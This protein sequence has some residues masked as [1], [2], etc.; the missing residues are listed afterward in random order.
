[1]DTPRICA[2]TLSFGIGSGCVNELASEDALSELLYADYLVLIS[3]TIDGLR[4]MFR[5]WK[6]AFV[7]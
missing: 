5:K 6:E 2:V 4:N 7:S 3:E 1:M